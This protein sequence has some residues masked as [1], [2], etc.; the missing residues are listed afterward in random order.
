MKDWLKISLALCTFGF[1]REFRPSE[2]FV[3]EFLSGEWRNIT[4]DQ[5]N[6]EVYP[7]GTYATL[8]LLVIVFL[9]TDIL[10]YKPIIIAS[11]CAGI[12]IWSMLL[13]TTSLLALQIVQVFYGFYMAAEV[14]YYTYMYAKVDKS[15]YQKV[16][17]NARA[18][19]LAGR[20]TASVV[21]Q[22]LFSFEIMNL[23]DLNYLT[24]G[25]QSISLIVAVLLPSVGIS[26]Y[27]YSIPNESE[28]NSVSNDEVPKET[29]EK[30]KEEPKFSFRRAYKL[31]W[32]HFLESYSN[33]KVVQW[34][35]WWALAMAG[36][37]MVQIY[38]QLLWQDIDEDREFLLNAGV[39][40]TLTL[41]GA[42]AAFLAGYLTSKTFKKLDMWILTACSLLQGIFIVI[43]SQTTLIWIAY[44]MYVMFGV[45]YSFMITIASAAVAQ[46]LADDCFAL[47]FGINTL[48]AL[49]FQTILTV[50]VISYLDLS[51]RD[52]F[53]VYGFYFIALALV[54][55]VTSI[56]K[57]VFFRNNDKYDIRD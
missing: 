20:F 23:R 41:F 32:K 33:P 27:F 21:A 44:A 31:L 40:A 13:W 46:Q 11:A 34:S 18:A 43:S 25:A 37:L 49:V 12:I 22:L 14:A 6:R 2:P 52:Q 45:L 42:I 35:F 50:V 8:G 10:R 29:N 28:N 36:F 15:K 5:L 17:G 57:L 54:Y 3:T 48:I 9:I 26:L 16:T 53:L 56:V 55:L 51:T 30:T 47:I 19:I 39:E 24:L 4:S 1:F 7:I 38:V